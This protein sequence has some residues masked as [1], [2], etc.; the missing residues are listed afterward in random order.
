MPRELKIKVREMGV[1]DA[2]L[3]HA[4]KAGTWEPEWAPL[5]GSDMGQLVPVLTAGELDAAL[6]GWTRPLF[7]KLGL[8][9]RLVVR[10]LPLLDQRCLEEE[11]CVLRDKGRCTPLSSKMPTCYRPG[12][13][14]GEA[15]LF[16]GYLL[17]SYWR[18]GV[19]VL[20]VKEDS[21]GA[22]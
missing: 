11:G 22:A 6:K 19:Y 17:L 18:S 3:I 1:I 14:E 16:L 4:D 20:V 21:D 9:P 7:D 15:A 5:Q 12:G 2:F 13:Q 8:A 10:K